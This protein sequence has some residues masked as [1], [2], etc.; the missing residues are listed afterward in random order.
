M[1]TSAEEWQAPSSQTIKAA[2]NATV[3]QVGRDYVEHNHRYVR[4]W[5]Y[6]RG[7]GIDT[8]ELDL[9][10]HAFVDPSI[11]DGIGQA[12]QALSTLTR[13]PERSHV[14]VL[15][16]QRG[17]G[18][19]T[20]ALHVLLKVG[21]PKER[22]NWLVLDWDQPRTEQIPH[23]AGYGFVLDLRGYRE[24]GD[25]FYTGLGDYQK[26]AQADGAYLIILADEGSWNPRMLTAVPAAH[27]VRPP[28]QQIAVTHLGHRAGNRV[29]WLTS[30]P[31]DTLLTEASQP[32][33]AARLVDLIARAK[34][35]DKEA[36]KQQFTNWRKH[37]EDWFMSHSSEAD[38]R[39]R[40][41]L[42]AT[43]LLENTPADTV[44][45]AADKLFTE[46][47]G[48]LPPGGALAGRDLQARLRAIY[49]STVGE[50]CISLDEERQGLAEA[51][52]RHVWQQRPQLR[53]ALLE[54]A[55]QI[56]TPN[57]IAVRHLNRIAD[58]LVQLSLL[59]GGLM[60]QNVMSGWIETGRAGHRQLAIEVLET[61]ALHPHT[62]PRVRKLLYD[63]ARNSSSEKLLA[64]VA[65]I[66]AGPLW[67]R[68]PHIALTRL[69]ILASRSDGQAHEAVASA[70]RRLA[71][72]PEQRA[73]VLSEIIQWTESPS[74]ATRRAG[75]STFLALADV[76]DTAHLPLTPVQ[77]SVSDATDD[78]TDQLFIRGW[79][80]ALE[81]PATA[82][83]AH[84][85]LADWLDSPALPDSRIMPIAAAVLRRRPYEARAA[86]LLL[87]STSELG[88]ARRKALFHSLLDGQQVHPPAVSASEASD[89]PY[90]T[91]T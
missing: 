7:V 10:E 44:L 25:D 14:L 21:V 70:V 46:V 38:L 34:K 17:T 5:E 2:D 42:I 35:N 9:A 84:T 76:T 43:A 62:G 40:A 49:A 55:S 72:T 36:V 79:R 12:A 1:S 22:I 69:R 90:S 78:L 18:R 29:D 57:G 24:L 41:L 59:P 54:W 13:L 61:M 16:G 88:R 48:V 73:M 6:L 52:L 8:T 53:H 26:A 47:G 45:E 75:T 58:C 51:V 89:N 30:P 77:E 85:R 15:C 4:G 23:T 83:E 20:A 66:C 74:S 68:Y 33:D 56:S 64:A 63:W 28:A 32:S 65:E 71:G 87:S 80:A 86:D 19:R 67:A 91:Q 37:L 3:T 50:E 31:L 82:L 81:E 11:P 39:E 60:V 27:L